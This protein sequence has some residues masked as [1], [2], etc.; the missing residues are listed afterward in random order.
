MRIFDQKASRS[1][2]LFVALS[3]LLVAYVINISFKTAAEDKMR[4]L[5]AVLL[6]I[7]FLKIVSAQESSNSVH[8]V[9]PKRAT[10]FSVFAAPDRAKERNK[11]K[12]REPCPEGRVRFRGQCVKITD[13]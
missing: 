1:K 6:L 4:T 11:K 7:F 8:L 10:D 5:A 2:R 9:E 13:F 12:H 3:T